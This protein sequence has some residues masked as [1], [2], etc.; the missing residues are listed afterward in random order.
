MQ[1]AGKK[2]RSTMDNIVIVSAIIEQR[3]IEKSS[4]YIFF[5]DAVKCFD[6]LWLQDCIIELAKLGYSNNDLE[7]LYKLNET[8]QVKIY[9]PYG[10]TENI[11]IKEVVKQGTTYGSIMC[12]A[13]TAR[14]NEIGEKVICKYG[15]IE[16]G[17]PVFMDDI[18]AIGK[19]IRNCR[20]METE[21]KIQYGLKK[22][23]YLTIRT[24][25]EKQE[26]IEKKV[27]EGKIDEVATYSY[28][29]IMLNKEGNLKE[30]IKETESKAS[31]IIREI[32]GI[33]SKQNVGQEEIRVKIKLFETCLIL[34]ILYGFKAWG[35]ILKSE[36]QAIEKIQNQSS[37]KIL[38]LPVTTSFTGLLME[39]GIWPEKERIEY[40]TLML[41]H[42]IISSN[43]ERISQKI[44]LEQ[45]KKGIINT[46]YEI[47]KEVG[48]SIRMNIDQAEKIKKINMEKKVKTKIKE[49]IQQKLI[50]D[51]KR[52]V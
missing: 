42:S 29:G 46:L 8:A 41:I 45:R 32:N 39:T 48:E 31:R 13:S 30:H 21:K 49:K 35:K 47:A 22:T 16:I 25:R 17:M 19:R 12:C 11:E 1:T 3:R 38:Q 44:I 4:T 27:K 18:A 24:G 52:K 51:S 14:V 26:L 15:N 34:A 43:K 40:S 6:K 23:K 50:D 5:E 33:S 2:Q 7:I 37:K 9:T 10:H 36:M 28:L 20:K